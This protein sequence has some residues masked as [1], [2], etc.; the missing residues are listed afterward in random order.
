[1]K[2]KALF[3]AGLLALAGAVPATGAAQGP[4]PSANCTAEFVVFNVIQAGAPHGAS[5]DLAII[6]QPPKDFP[7]MSNVGFFSSTN[8]A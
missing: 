1:M 4:N 3:L 7:P 8:C 5:E 6:A 2:R